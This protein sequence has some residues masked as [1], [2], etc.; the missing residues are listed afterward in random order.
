MNSNNSP[1]SPCLVFVYGTLKPNH[2]NYQQYCS[3]KVIDSQ[4]AIALGQIFALPMGYPAM[5]EG[6][7]Q[8]HGYLLT[9]ADSNILESLDQLEDY[10]GD[11][12]AS[13][14]LYVRQRIEVFTLTGDTLGLA[15]VY[16]MTAEQVSQFQGVLQTDG[17][18][19]PLNLN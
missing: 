18:W 1:D 6:N 14:N 12:P 8:V 9:F 11:R 19:K 13:E 16:M 15:W 3:T 2:S 4:P 5:I 17:I 10:Q 7:D